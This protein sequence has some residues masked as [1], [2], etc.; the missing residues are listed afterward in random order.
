HVTAKATPGVQ[1][2]VRASGPSGVRGAARVQGGMLNSGGPSARPSSRRAYPYKSKT[3]SERVQRES[4]GIV[5]PMMAA[6]HNAV[7]GKGPCGGQVDGGGKRE[8]MAGGSGPNHPHG[9]KPADKVR[10]LQRR[11]WVA[12]KRSPTRR[13]HALYDRIY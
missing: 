2:P 11:L 9:R 6:P 4:E 8:G 1:V 3:K 10:Q 5:V 13:F 12:A 7:G